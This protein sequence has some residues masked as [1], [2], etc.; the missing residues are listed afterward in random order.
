LFPSSRNRQ[1]DERGNQFDRRG[2]WTKAVELE[3]TM[4]MPSENDPNRRR[5]SGYERSGEGAW[6]VLPVIIGVAILTIFVYLVFGAGFSGVPDGSVTNR[7]V[8]S[9]STTT[10]TPPTPSIPPKSQ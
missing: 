8:E 6:G 7:R 1:S 3:I 9:P 2:L 10:P 5:P 4:T